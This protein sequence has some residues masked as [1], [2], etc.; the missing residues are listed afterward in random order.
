[1]EMEMEI[2]QAFCKQVVSEGASDGATPDQHIDLYYK[3]G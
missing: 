1:M 3:G 2:V